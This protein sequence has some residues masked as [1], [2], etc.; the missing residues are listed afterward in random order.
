MNGSALI[1]RQIAISSEHF[2]QCFRQL[3]GSL[4]PHPGVINHLN[5]VPGER[6]GGKGL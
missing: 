4:Y 2:S 5:P 6:G 3:D 1:Q